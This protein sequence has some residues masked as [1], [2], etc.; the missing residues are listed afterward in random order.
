[1]EAIPI[2]TALS[3]DGL[4]DILRSGLIATNDQVDK[5]VGEQVCS[6]GAGFL[7]EVI[8]RNEPTPYEIEQHLKA[9]AAVLDVA[10]RALDLDETDDGVRVYGTLLSRGRRTREALNR[11]ALMMAAQSADEVEGG[12]GNGEPS[13]AASRATARVRTAT[14]GAQDLRVLVG[15]AIRQLEHERKL[16]ERRTREASALPAQ[17]QRS[18]AS[19][20]LYGRSLRQVI[21][22]PPSRGRPGRGDDVFDRFLWSLWHIYVDATHR[23]PG[24][25]VHSAAMRTAGQACGPFLA[26]CIACLRW[27]DTQVPPDLRDRDAKLRKA[28]ASTPSALRPRLQRVIRFGTMSRR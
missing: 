8:R 12:Q 3:R 10:A 25:S 21:S 5:S 27:L 23:L 17:Q 28:L 19:P 11:V 15:A 26:F 9:A 24:T 18:E 13:S 16:A 4:H 14:D 22:G 20:P 1:M 6:A 2:R 7:R